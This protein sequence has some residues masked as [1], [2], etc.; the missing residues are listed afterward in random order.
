VSARVAASALVVLAFSARGACAQDSLVFKGADR[1]TRAAL[2]TI[3]AEASARGLPTAPIVSKVQFALVVHAPSARIV[4]TAKTVADRLSVARD[5]IAT[6]TL[7]AD[8]ANGEDALSFRIPKEILTRIHVAAPNRSIAV[9]LAVLTQLVASN[10]PADHASDIVVR[11]MRQGATPG[12]LLALGNNVSSDVQR[13]A[14]GAESADIRLRGLTP[15]LP[16][17]AV[18]TGD[19]TASSPAASGPRKP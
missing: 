18:T 19:L 9:P 6:D 1:E 8:I 17:G 11:L 2:A 7:S 4:A 12:Q 13:G 15:L 5:A 14:K 16:P 3:V 10:V